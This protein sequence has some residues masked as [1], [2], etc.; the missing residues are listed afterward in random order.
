MESSADFDVAKNAISWEYELC[1]HTGDSLFFV[2]G[3]VL[4]LDFG[5]YFAWDETLVAIW[6]RVWLVDQTHGEVREIVRRDEQGE[7]LSDSNFLLG[8]SAP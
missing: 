3:L 2:Q 8:L 1:S 6:N 7:E 5:L 4:L